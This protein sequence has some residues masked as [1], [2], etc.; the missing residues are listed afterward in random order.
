MRG[1]RF[2]AVGECMV[3]LFS[4]NPV[5]VYRAERFRCSFGGDAIQAALAASNLGT[6][7]AVATVVG[8]DPFAGSLLSWLERSGISTDL[9]VRRPGFTGLY[10]I[11]IDASGERSFV[12]YRNGSASSTVDARD[13]AWIDPPEAVLVSGITQ[14]VSESSR[15][16]AVEAARRTREAGGLVVYDVNYRSRLWGED[17]A[18]AR[19][20]FG[21]IRP[22][23]QVLRVSAPEDTAILVDE[24]SPSDAA[25]ALSARGPWTVLVGCGGGGAVLAVGGEVEQIPAPA[26]AS[27]DTTGAGDALT[28]AF[29]HG[30]LAG[31]SPGEAARL[32]VAAGSL[33]VTRRGGA[34]AIPSGEEVRA[35]VERMRA[36][37]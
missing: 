4:E 27:I 25:R 21:E 1:I 12:Y 35:L 9:V 37:V 19:E 11:S 29:V 8:D 22:L 16:A 33:A 3:E 24:T 23:C 18:A 20:A 5:P 34:S 7:S 6:P 26:V 30:L 10:L 36:P 2:V 17:P 32:G 28:G 14:A 31:L 15:R 13:V